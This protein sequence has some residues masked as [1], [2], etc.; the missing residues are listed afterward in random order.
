MHLS[1]LLSNSIIII[2]ILLSLRQ[3]ETNLLG[4]SLGRER[5]GALDRSTDSTVNDDLRKDTKSTSNTEQ[6][7]VEVLLSKTV[8][9]QQD[10]G[11]GVDIGPGVFDLLVSTQDLGGDLVDL[12][13][14]LEQ[15]VV[16]H[17][18]ETEL[19]LGGVTG[20][21]LTEDSMTV[22]GNNTA[23]LESV[24]Q[25]LLDLLVGDVR[26][27]LLTHAEDPLEH[28]LVSTA[29]ERTG[30]TVETSSNGQV[31]GGEGGA[32]Q[33][34]GVGRNV[35]TLVVRVDGK[36]Q[37]HQLSELGVV[38]AELLDEVGTVVEVGVGLSDNTILEDIAVDAGSNRGQ[39][40]D[41]VK[42]VLESVLPVVLLGNTLLVG[43]GELRGGLQSV[44]GN[45][46]LS[47]GV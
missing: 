14:E 24:P 47:H 10:T 5:L 17:V 23:S 35:A 4:K 6:N 21:G 12:G 46:Q 8:V 25:V 39:L 26:T 36:V 22:A 2:Y 32:D 18:L 42:G 13:D 38:D 7:G 19:A 41:Q 27:D 44:D 40:G 29:M 45:A 30:K 15:V 20:V 3:S 37:T 34:G 16:G 28:L 9:L 11:V 33:V 43:L 1:S 31:G